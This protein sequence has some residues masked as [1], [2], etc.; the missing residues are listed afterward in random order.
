[1]DDGPRF[2]NGTEAGLGAAGRSEPRCWSPKHVSNQDRGLVE[3]K[4]PGINVV[5]EYVQVSK[6]TNLTREMAS[7]VANITRLDD[8][9]CVWQNQ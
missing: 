5:V 2:F 9:I 1:V 7:N 6:N 4:I 8:Y 3:G